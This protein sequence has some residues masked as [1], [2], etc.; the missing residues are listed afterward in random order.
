MKVRLIKSE[1]DYAAAMTRLSNLMDMDPAAGS[2]TEAELEL[3]ALVIEDYERRIVP[4][5]KPTPVQAILFRLEQQGLSRK[6]LAPF[7][8]SL[9]KV[10]EVLSGKRQLSIAMIRRLH[11]GLGI[12]ADVLIGAEAEET[13][14]M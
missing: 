1:E 3:L 11:Q 10:S 6:D 9:P 8:G 4:Q 14:L 5:A 12:P 7:I 13:R 2:E